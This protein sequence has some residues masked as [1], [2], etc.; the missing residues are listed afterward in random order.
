M[1]EARAELESRAI[2][3][4]AVSFESIEVARSYALPA[5]A[6]WPLLI[7]ESRR[8]YHAFGLTRGG[9]WDIWGPATW[10]AYARALGRGQWPRVH[11]AD[12][13]Q[14][15]GD[16]LLAPD[17]TVRMCFVGRGPADRPSVSEILGH[18][19]PP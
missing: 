18:W 6:Q 3:V 10:W 16:V 17:R 7:D 13:N 15:G 19:T 4:A 8:L 11:T 14:R 2:E 5:G 9:L 1:C 12:P